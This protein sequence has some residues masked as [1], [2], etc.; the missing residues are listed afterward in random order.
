MGMAVGMLFAVLG[1][2]A[3]W[4]AVQASYPVFQPPP[5]Q[6]DP[7]AGVPEAI[8]KKL[9]RNNAIVILAVVAGLIAA[10]LAAGEAALR[11]SWALIVVA[12]VVSGLVAAALGSW[13]G[14]AGHAL[15]EYLRPRRELSELARTAMVQTLM[16]GLL[17]CSVGVGVAAVVGRRVRGRLSCFI[18]GLLGG[19]LAGMLYP[20]AASVV[21]LITPVITDT[22]IPARA[23]ER[24]LW[25]GLT[26]L[27]LGLLLPAVCGQGAC[28]R[29]R[30]PAETR[31][32]ED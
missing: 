6:I 27:I 25:I 2:V 22:L 11:R 4:A 20:V 32:Q 3:S 18:A 7:M 21:G 1:G 19:V 28:C 8:Q 26:A 29:C 5:D 31:P 13:A 9:D 16:L 24:L 14:W 12:L 17:G 15:F 30:T 10:A 23:G